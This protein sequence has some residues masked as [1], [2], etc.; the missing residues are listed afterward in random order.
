MTGDASGSIFWTVGSSMPF[1]RSGIVSWRRSRTSCVATSVFFSST[2]RMTTWE[3]PSLVIDVI[4]SMPLIVLTASSIFSVI[5]VSTS[6]G[7]APGRRVVTTTTG[8][9]TFG[10]RSSPSLP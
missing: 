9:S 7:A 4:S 2:K 5:S 10:K 1:G 8:M 6:S 3:T